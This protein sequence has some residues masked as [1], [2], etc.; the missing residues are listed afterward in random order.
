MREGE[1]VVSS[2]T[3]RGGPRVV[4][5]AGLRGRKKPRARPTKTLR[6]ALTDEVTRG[7]L[8]LGCA[9]RS[10]YARFDDAG[11]WFIIL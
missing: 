8:L 3:R 2:R 11:V 4:C 1:R 5:A 6:L 7:L 9:E 10:V